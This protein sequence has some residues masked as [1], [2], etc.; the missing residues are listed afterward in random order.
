MGG[1]I[2][3]ADARVVWP[4]FLVSVSAATGAK[5]PE[6]KERRRNKLLCA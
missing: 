5:V 4:L 1:S 2:S 3:S 6:A